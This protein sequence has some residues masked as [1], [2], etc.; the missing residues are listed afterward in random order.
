VGDAWGSGLP[1]GPGQGKSRE[2]GVERIISGSFIAVDPKVPRDEQFGAVGQLLDEGIIQNAGLSEVSVDD[3]EAA[4]RIFPV[5]TVQ[6]LYNLTERKSEDVLTY[7]AATGSASSLG[8]RSLPAT[9]SNPRAPSLVSQRRTGPRRLRS[10][11]RG[12]CRR[13]RHAAHS[14]DLPGR[15]P[16]RERGGGGGLAD[17]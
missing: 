6:N 3:I 15:S 10:R 5:A 17:D 8:I 16:P 1:D 4:R 7:C 11:S 13:V 2:I 12:S 9:W 14:G